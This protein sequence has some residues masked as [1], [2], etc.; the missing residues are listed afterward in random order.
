MSGPLIQDR[1][2]SRRFFFDVWKKHQAAI[3]LQELEEIVLGVI[4]DHPEYHALLDHEKEVLPQEFAPEQGTSN[5]FLHMGMHI[6]IREQLGCN[7]P[8]GI[9]LAFQHLRS[10][11][12]SAH[13]LE[14]RVMECL[15]E[16]LW[17]AQRHNK[18]PDEISYL[19]CVKKISQK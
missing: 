17:L 9:T 16:A 8:E 7:R 10:K 5:P 11:F 1:E 3:P 15:G 13:D 14:H 12:A 18:L 2:T 6:A 19:E 4:L